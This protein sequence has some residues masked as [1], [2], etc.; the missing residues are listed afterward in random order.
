MEPTA[1]LGYTD[2]DNNTFT[3]V[4]DGATMPLF[5]GGQGGSHIFATVRASGFPAGEDGKATIQL[6]QN[7]TLSDSG[8]V[9]HDFT[10]TVSFEPIGGG[11]FEIASRF[12]FL[13]AVPTD[14]HGQ[15]ADIDFVL[16]SLDQPEITAQINQ[17]VRLELQP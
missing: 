12:V 7:V 10:Q 15:N 8:A 9:L 13:D 1:E 17:T 4:P 16:Q 11:L 2:L 5:T 3:P 6:A 14:L